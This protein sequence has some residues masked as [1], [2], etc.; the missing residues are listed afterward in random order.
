MS[1]P[2]KILHPIALSASIALLAVAALAQQPKPPSKAFAMSVESISV[3]GKHRGYTNNELS[4]KLD[5]DKEMTF[6]VQIPGDKEQAW[7][8]QFEMSSRI[9]VTYYQV[10]GKTQLVATSI[11]KA[12]APVKR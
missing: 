4:L 8:K 7:H 10:P 6:L 2:S 9:T 3:T 11:T 12:G 1:L 5:N